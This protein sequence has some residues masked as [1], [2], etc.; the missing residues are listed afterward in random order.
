MANGP[1]LQRI[2]WLRLHVQLP[3]DAPTETRDYALARVKR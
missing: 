3:A 1:R 2:H